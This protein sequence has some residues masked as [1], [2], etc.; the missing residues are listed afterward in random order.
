MRH[1]KPY[2]DVLRNLNF[3]KLW[4]TQLC[5]QLTRYILSFAV[6]LQAFRLTDSS[7]AVSFILVAFGLATVVFGSLA[8][9]Y[10]DR[11]DK[12]KLLVIITFAQALLV[13]CYIPFADNIIIMGIITFFYSSFNQFYLPAEAPSIPHLVEKDHLLIANSFFSFTANLSLIVGFAIAGPISLAF[14]PQAPFWACFILMGLAGIAAWGLPSLSPRQDHPHKA[15][16]FKNVWS[17]FKEGL[18]TVLS[19]KNLH[20]PFI[21]LFAAQ[22][23]NGMII[24]IAPAFVSNVLKRNLEQGV[25]YMIAPLAIGILVGTMFLG[26]EGQFFSKKRMVLTGFTGLG[27]FSFLIAIMVSA[28][29]YWLYVVLAFIL[30]LFNTYVFAPSHSIIQSLTQENVRGRVYASLF[31]LLQLGGTLPTVIVGALADYTSASAILGGLGIIL[32]IFTAFLLSFDKRTTSPVLSSPD[33]S[34]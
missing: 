20:F 28:Q 14:G 18:Q 29:N 10:A 19:T 15:Y 22:V 17:E 25:L 9:V 4:F 33:P 27:I 12:K 7:L 6:I 16:F 34:P 23:Y 32:I 11:F 24:T 30:G 26:L 8:G 13:L 5:T 2:F 1:I 31:L 3:T 21:A